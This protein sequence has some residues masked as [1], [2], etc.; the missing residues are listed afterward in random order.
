M[1][2]KALGGTDP[3]VPASASD[4]YDHLKS[5]RFMV[6]ICRSCG[7]A[8]FPVS[9]LCRHCGSRTRVGK[10]RT[11]RGVLLECTRSHVGGIDSQL[12]YVEMA[13]IR[14]VGT[15]DSDAAL[16]EGM[17]VKMDSCGLGSDG[18]P[19]YLFSPLAA[20]KTTRPKTDRST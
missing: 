7:R 1:V 10:P 14:V 17:K 5:G 9:M 20:K 15:F 3:A 18:R 2:I 16:K 6:S 4:F 13:G 19:F 11:T 8:S 12:G